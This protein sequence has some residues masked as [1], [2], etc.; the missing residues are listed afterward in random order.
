MH[1]LQYMYSIFLNLQQFLWVFSGKNVSADP[2][3]RGSLTSSDTRE[4]IE[5]DF[6]LTPEDVINP[7]INYFSGKLVWHSE[8]AAYIIL[9]VAIFCVFNS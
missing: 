1:L 3:G 5:I 9:H 2:I 8:F 4:G 7:N 6:I